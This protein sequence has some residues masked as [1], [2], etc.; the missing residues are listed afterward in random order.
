MLIVFLCNELLA[1]VAKILLSRAVGGV[2]HS[3][4]KYK[5]SMSLCMIEWGRVDTIITIYNTYL[6]SNSFNDRCKHNF[7]I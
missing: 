3:E 4:Q 6:S 7:S 5:L 1:P 2:A